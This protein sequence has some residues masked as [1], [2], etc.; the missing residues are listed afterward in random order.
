MG[1]LLYSSS[2]T[3]NVYPMSELF[4]RHRLQV[5][6]ELWESVLRQECGQKMVDLLRQ[7]RDL[8]SPEG[9]ATHDQASSAVELIEQLNINEAIRAAR[10]FA[11]YFQLI[12]I[13]EQEYEQKQQLTRYSDTETTDQEYL[14]NI[15]YST[16]QRE[17]DLPVTKALGADAGTQSWIENTQI[18]QKGTFSALFPLLFKL[19]VP[20]Q[21]IQRLISQLD[22]RLVFTAHPTEIVRHTIRDKQKQVVDLL[23]KLDELENRTGGYPWEA[24]EVK[25]RLLEEIRLWWRTDELHQFKPTVL[26]E[27]DYALH[28]F[29]EVLFDGIP[30]L[31]KR[32]KY[33]LEQ[34]FPWLEPPS[35]NFC[36]FGSWVGSDRDGNPSVTPEVTW[37]TACYQRKMVLERYIKSVKQLIELLSVSMHWSDVLPDLLESLELDQSTLSDVYDALALRYRQEPYRLK[38]AYVLRRLENTRDRNLALYNREVPQNENSSMY[39]SGSEFLEELRLIQRNLT[40]T[41]LGCRELENLICQVEIFDFNL[42]QL[43]IR[44]E[45]SRHSDALNEILEY[46]QVLPQ[47]YNELSESQRVAWLTG[48]LQTRRPLIP[49]ELPF[50]EKTNDVIETFRILRSLQQEFGI[51]I[52]QT[53]IISMCREVSDVL[54]VLI[55]AKEAR[56]FD[57]AIAVGSIRVVPLFETVEDLQ[58][59]NSVMSQLF[60]LP[61]YRALLAGGYEAINPE[62]AGLTPQIPNSPSSS[63]LNPNLQEVMLGYSDSNKD[64]GF[65]SSNWE[66]HKAQKSLQKIAEKYGVNLRIFHGRWWFGGTGWRPCL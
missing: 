46:L 13:I 11:L 9:Q 12:N 63:I 37:K 21:Q 65:L 41:G 14:A 10:A 36:S 45:S 40:E 28:Y 34:T 49:S 30:Q 44:Q 47:P 55:L 25:E 7:L 52:C 26:D 22:I 58:R 56:L 19:N 20:P 43:D 23:Q 17:D 39:R 60:Q 27:V 2:Q 15:I 53:Y 8:C 5:V 62:T 51:S 6:E 32:L 4:L 35:K 1:S 16:N 33:S 48:E 59:S 57:P 24:A 50:S 42:T 54:E 18:N 66:I 61:L 64:S 31:Y 38:L 3:A 29:Q